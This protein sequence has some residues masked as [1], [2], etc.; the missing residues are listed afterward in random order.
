MPAPRGVRTAAFVA[1]VGVLGL[2]GATAACTD[3]TT[4]DCSD[5]QCLVVGEVSETGAGPDAG[6]SGADAASSEDGSDAAPPPAAGD[7]ATD[8]AGG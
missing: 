2:C 1:L 3:G 8:G 5:A 6:E 7:G 4:P